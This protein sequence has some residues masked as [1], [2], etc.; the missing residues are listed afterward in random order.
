LYYIYIKA[1]VRDSPSEIFE[2]TEEAGWK[3]AQQPAEAGSDVDGCQPFIMSNLR[4]INIP[5]AA[6][7]QTG[8]LQD[9]IDVLAAKGGGTVVV[10]EGV[11]ECGAIILR[12]NINLH[13]AKGAILRAVSNYEAFASAVSKVVSEDSDRAFLFARGVR[14]LRITG[15]G[16]LDGQGHLWCSGVDP[17]SGARTPHPERPRMLVIEDCTD[18]EIAGLSIRNSPMWTV[19]LIGSRG[20]RISNVTIENDMAQPNTDGIV[21]DSC[22]GVEIDSVSVS[23]ADDSIVIK[24]CRLPDGALIGPCE[25]VAVRRVKTRSRGC[26]FK[27]G[28]ETHSDIRNILFEDCIATE[29]NRGM[30]IFSRD[31]GAISNVIFR[32][33]TVHCVET[34]VGY[35]GTGEAIAL[36]II[37]R[38]PHLAT[39]GGITNVVVEDIDGT[40]QGAI[41]F[42]S[43]GPARI[44]NIRLSNV[45]LIQ[46]EGVLGHGQSCDLRPTPQDLA[47]P[48]GVI[49]RANAWF[50]G[51]DGRVV[52]Y[53]SYP[54]GMPSIYVQNVPGIVLNDVRIERPAPLPHGW[55]EQ[56]LVVADRGFSIPTP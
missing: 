50:K 56:A 42:T 53:F 21:I 19:H 34:P 22:C 28:T 33:L 38:R 13:L 26:S 29:T 32:R 12:D 48:P 30:G 41:N 52:G 39:A 51:T 15:D 2:G 9:A 5:S 46:Q 47:P 8:K 45:R 11:H 16:E 10:E 24:T 43:I 37:D 1:T 27:I 55:N 17:E 18:V 3:S 4:V 20:L 14:G 35:W 31:G 44:G 23:A 36:N 7:D 6:S 40:M 54:D 49:G 25:N